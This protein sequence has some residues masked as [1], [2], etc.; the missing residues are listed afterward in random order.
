M[1][2]E[3]SVCVAY[4]MCIAWSGAS[5]PERCQARCILPSTPEVL[6]SLPGSETSVALFCLSSFLHRHAAIHVQGRKAPA[7]SSARSGSLAYLD[8]LVAEHLF[9]ITPELA[10]RSEAHG[11]ACRL[12]QE[13]T[14]KLRPALYD[15]GWR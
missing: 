5:A 12:V 6:I 4:L 1:H 8:Q 11:T 7:S 13:F 9:L 15:A 14:G 3:L 10:S 2:Q